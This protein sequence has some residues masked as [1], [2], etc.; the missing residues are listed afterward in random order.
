[1]QNSE[2][3]SYYNELVSQWQETNRKGFTEDTSRL[4]LHFERT[5]TFSEE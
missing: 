1:M 4:G 3:M 5:H 2:I